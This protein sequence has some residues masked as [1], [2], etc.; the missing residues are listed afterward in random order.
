MN[1][2]VTTEIRLLIV[3]DSADDAELLSRELRKGGFEF[4]F[5]LVEDAAGLSA[6]LA[7]TDWD[8]IISDHVMPQFNSFAALKLV[9]EKSRDTPFIVISGTVGEEVAVEVMKSG[10]NDYMLKDNLIRLVPAVRRELE[11]AASRKQ[12]RQAELALRK[13]EAHIRLIAD[14]LPVL[15]TH[16]DKDLRF[17]FV[18]KTAEEW[19]CLSAEDVLGKTVGDV[20]GVKAL[21]KL[22]GHLDK[23]TSG[24]RVNFT[25]TLSYP[26]GKTRN[27]HVSYVPDISED[28]LVRGHFGL[29]VDLTAHK[30]TEAALVET[31]A[32][33]FSAVE[34][35]S[36]GFILYDPDDR[37][38]MC[39]EKYKDFY[40]QIK[41]DLVP[42]ANLE[43]LARK[44]FE[45]GAVKGSAEDEDLSLNLRLSQQESAQGSREQELS[46][47]RWLLCS[48]RR[49]A[50]GLTVGIRTDITDVKQ[51]ADQ[52]RRAQRL[53][54]VGQLTGGV[55]HDFNNIL[56]AIIGNLDLIEDGGGIRDKFD[57]DG[58]AIALR[59][60]LRG[61][62]LTHRLLA[63]SRQQ[64][65]DAEATNINDILTPFHELATRTIGEDIT[66]EMK[67]SADLWPT[68]VDVGQL[69][70]A[71]LNL[72][73]NAR[74]AMPDGG[75]LTVETAN[76]ILRDDGVMAYENLEPGAY[77]MIAVRDNGTGMP[78]DV[79]ARVFEPF[80]TTKDVGKGSGLG[81]SMVFGFARQTGGQVVIS[82]EEGAGTT[83]SIYLPRADETTTAVS[84]VVEIEQED[85]R[86][87]ETILV[88]EDDSDVRNFL[89]KVL[90]RLG[91]FV[92]EA[93]DGPAAL[94]IMAATGVINLLLTDVILPRGMSGRDVANV[95]HER[96][97]AAGVLFSSGYTRDVLNRRG[98][99]DD[100]VALLNKPY[101]P[102]DMARQ[103]R[104]ILDNRYMERPTALEA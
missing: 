8:I 70:N 101:R 32:Y 35:I 3:D 83:V 46:D 53:E 39:N 9:R 66:I 64:A 58:I 88:V 6:A 29:V 25:E 68:M 72:A 104:E 10:A 74:D 73:I 60:A 36:E 15:I 1:P 17:Q 93:E 45:R 86:G 22:Q 71:L 85:S 16:L 89:V 91:Y 63:F 54:A 90:N 19:Y 38:I 2:A 97:P 79:R 48:D 61:A 65:L 13:S 43:D 69:E 47:G 42:G 51:T 37:F 52:L 50:D 82:S 102:R 62:E 33:L 100:G 28:G 99:L 24:E 56:A 18:N 81:L 80:F 55:A 34:S 94:E 20:I 67:P 87:N 49:T 44:A 27:V 98:Q 57:Q 77:V 7:A 31:E 21:E 40:P 92:L 103:V 59:S 41:D 95:F 4:T 75:R 12:R 26:D 11:E 78:A 5:E 23:V 76:K 96:Y 14:N 30:Q 84:A